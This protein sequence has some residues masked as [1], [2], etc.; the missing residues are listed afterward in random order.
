VDGLVHDGAAAI[1]GQGALPAGVI[2]PGPVPLHVG[3]AQ[4]EPAKP[5][6]VEGG[7]EGA[8]PGAEPGLED[9]PDQDPGP[10]GGLE[11]GVDPRHGDLQGLF[12][13][14]V[15]SGRDGLQGRFQVRAARGEDAHDMDVGTGKQGCQVVGMERNAMAP[16][17]GLSPARVEVDHPRQAHVVLRAQRADGLGVVVGDHACA[18]QAETDGFPGVHFVHGSLS[19]DGMISARAWAVSASSVTLKQSG[20]RVSVPAR[21]KMSRRRSV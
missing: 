18:D 2:L 20:W 9:G 6:G 13:D 8:R 11:D 21:S 12:D 10:L 1:Q 16:G 7:L 17:E 4:H 3:A 19:A 5:P 14:H 15:A